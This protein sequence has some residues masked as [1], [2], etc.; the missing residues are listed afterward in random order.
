MGQPKWHLRQIIVLGA[1]LLSLV[2]L[3]DLNQRLTQLSRLN[4]ERDQMHTEV[5]GMQSTIQ[6]LQTAIAFA[7]SEAAVESYARNQANM[8]REGEVPI[9]PVPRGTSQAQI[10]TTP[11]PEPPPVHKWEVWWALFFGR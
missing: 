9:I 10:S 6:S 4:E 11:T 8:V 1:L 7:T 3:I 2:L 5:A